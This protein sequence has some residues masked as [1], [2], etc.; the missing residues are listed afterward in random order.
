MHSSAR[1][2]RV[3]GTAS[4]LKAYKDTAIAQDVLAPGIRSVTGAQPGRSMQ[5]RAPFPR[6]GKRRACHPSIPALFRPA[7]ACLTV[8]KT[9]S[10]CYFAAVSIA[11]SD[12]G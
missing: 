7:A 8:R 11:F 12:S 3:R 10:L 6:Q 9:E 4:P 2:T 5:T 1:D